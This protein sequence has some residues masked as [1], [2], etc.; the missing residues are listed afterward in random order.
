MTAGTNCSR[1]AAGPY[2]DLNG[3]CVAAEAGVLVDK[4]PE[5]VTAVQNRDEFHMICGGHL[6][7][8]PIFFCLNPSSGVPLYLQLMEQVKHAVET[9]ALR[10]G[11]QFPPIRAMAQEL[12]MNSNT[13]VRA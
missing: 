4:S 3:C 7:L 10:A 9:G 5:V 13:V 1:A 12:V 11:E 2:G 6:C 8:P